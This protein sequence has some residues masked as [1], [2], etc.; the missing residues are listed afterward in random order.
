M[1][2]ITSGQTA[3]AR[4]PAADRVSYQRMRRDDS[5]QRVSKVTRRVGVLAV[6]MVGALGFY[7]SRALPGHP[8]GSP[9]HTTGPIF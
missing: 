1:D 2:R 7:V 5:L 8:T 9:T 3:A 6:A 4:R